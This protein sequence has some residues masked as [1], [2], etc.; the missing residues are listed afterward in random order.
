MKGKAA[1]PNIPANGAYPNPRGRTGSAEIN[2]FSIIFMGL[3]DVHWNNCVI[4]PTII[5]VLWGSI[6]E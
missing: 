2:K 3:S 5:I 6:G 4:I 1:R